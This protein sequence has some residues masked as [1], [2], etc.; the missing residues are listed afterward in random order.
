MSMQ[1]TARGRITE[2]QFGKA[3]DYGAAIANLAG[4]VERFGFGRQSI[5]LGSGVQRT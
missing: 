5:R 2:A 4:G 1:L 3:D